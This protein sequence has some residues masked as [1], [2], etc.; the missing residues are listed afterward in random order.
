MPR[1]ILAFAIAAAAALPAAPAL[2]AQGARAPVRTVLQ[3]RLDESTVLRLGQPA[4]TLVIGN[5]SVADAVVHDGSTVIVTG[6]SFGTTNLIAL[7]RSGE[8]LA[9][10]QIHVGQPDSSILTVQRGAE[11]ETYACAPQCRRAPVLGDSQRQFGEAIAQAAA[12]N[13]LATSAPTR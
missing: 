10:R 5:P 12:R 4:Q 6:K 2:H 1:L 7:S 13:G 8:I 3:V 9:E 11:L